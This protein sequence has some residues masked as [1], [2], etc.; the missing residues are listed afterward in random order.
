MFPTWRKSHHLCPCKCR[1][2]SQ[3]IRQKRSRASPQAVPHDLQPVP[4]VSLQPLLQNAPSPLADPP[5]GCDH[6]AVGVT[7]DHFLNHD[8]TVAIVLCHDVVVGN[9]GACLERALQLD[10][11]QCMTEDQFRNHNVTMLEMMVH[12]SE[13]QP[14]G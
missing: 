12:M 6:S 5:S 2:L 14:G 8:V 1:L 11:L 7:G 3:T 9:D 4:R 10:V 13:N